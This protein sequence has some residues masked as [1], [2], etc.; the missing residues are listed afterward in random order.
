MS[1]NT[2]TGMSHVTSGVGRLWILFF[3]HSA[4]ACG[5]ASPPT[6]TYPTVAKE[7]YVRL[8]AAV[9]ST[10]KRAVSESERRSG[11]RV[12]AAIVI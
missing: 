8:A 9:R 3:G 2:P 4:G 11:S 12:S 10:Y 1:L 5:F 6:P 7:L